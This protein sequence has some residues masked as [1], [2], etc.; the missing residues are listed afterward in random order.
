MKLP[1]DYWGSG[2]GQKVMYNHDTLCTVLIE[3]LN[4][5]LL[6]P[7]MHKFSNIYIDLTPLKLNEQISHKWR[8]G[9]SEHHWELF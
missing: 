3:I 4:S 8:Y 9:W 1:S 6:M 7:K 5:T 2:K